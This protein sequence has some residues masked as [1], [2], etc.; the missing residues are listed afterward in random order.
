MRDFDRVRYD[1][2][3]R[4]T[5]LFADI[6]P[7]EDCHDAVSGARSGCVDACYIRVG[8]RAANQRNMQHAHHLDVIYIRASAGNQ[9]RVFPSLDAGT[10][11]G[12]RSSGSHTFL[13]AVVNVFPKSNIRSSLE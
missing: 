6:L 3:A 1:P 11:G 4:Q 13:L 7:G 12:G 10:E 2:A 8:I 9:A 5:D